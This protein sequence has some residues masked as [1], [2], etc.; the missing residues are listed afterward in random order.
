MPGIETESPDPFACALHE[1]SNALTVV[2]GWADVGLRAGSEDEL[3]RALEVVREH[4]RR[5]QALARRAIGA[6]VESSRSG[7]TGAAAA[8]FIAVSIRPMALARG[9][10]IEV[11]CGP[12]TEVIVSDEATLLQVLTNLLLNATQFSP[13]DSTVS[14]TVD[15]EGDWFR[16]GIQD[17]GPGV[18]P[19][20]RASL[21]SLR[22]TTRAEGA[23]IGLVHSFALARE[24][25]GDLDYVAGDRGARFEL[26]WPVARS[27][28]VRPSVRAASTTALTGTTI[29]LV[30]DDVAVASL[31]ELSC[32]ARGAEVIIAADRDEL[33][34]VLE[35]TPRIDAVLL[36]LSPVEEALAETLDEIGARAPSAPVILMSG[37][38]TGVPAG[39]EGRFSAWVRKPFDMEEL[40]QTVADLVGPRSSS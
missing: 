30:E 34:R 32:G 26:T 7:R 6:A 8:E 38:P 21:F 40:L 14:L 17:E 1:V 22:E 19:E 18:P 35:V 27:T 31:V 23:G 10:E 15:R 25:G 37:Q 3:R 5:G 2:L 24:R 13:P 33:R 9:V 28:A 20:R 16:F 11:D 36:D 39:G 29:L 12:A 4:A